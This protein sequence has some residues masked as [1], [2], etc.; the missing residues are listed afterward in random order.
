MKSLKD[1][2]LPQDKDKE[3]PE[4]SGLKT[5]GPEGEITAGPYF[6]IISS[7]WLSNVVL[8]A[9]TL[10]LLL[11]SLSSAQLRDFF[12]FSISKLPVKLWTGVG[13]AFLEIIFLFFFLKLLYDK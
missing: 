4:V 9:P 13:S 6:N 1:K 10:H 7:Q 8:F 12:V 3:T 2:F 5:A 11:L